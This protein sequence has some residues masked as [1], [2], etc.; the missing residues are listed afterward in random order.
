MTQR[1]DPT[2]RT[3]IGRVFI[4][5]S[6][7]G[8]IARA[9][10]DIG[11]LTDP[12]PGR[13]HA[14]VAS[15]RPAPTWE[16]FFPAIDHLVMGRGTYEKVCTFDGWPYADKRVLVLSRTLAEDDDRVTVV[17]TLSEATAALEA[18]GAEQVYVDG[19]QVIQSF[20]RAGLIDEMTVTRAPVLL[21]SGLPLFGSLDRDLELELT[22]SHVSDGM[23][24]ACYR[25]VHGTS[26]R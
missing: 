15:D 14:A 3:W 8:F 9:D 18:G 25:I 23:V 12:P 11:W 19:G 4:A 1:D 7:D 21:G 2:T 5:T 22:A 24:Y 26:P 20:L 6:M 16:T 17:R 10:G 13:S